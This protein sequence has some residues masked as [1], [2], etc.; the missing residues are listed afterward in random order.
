[1]QNLL[2]ATP[3]LAWLLF[4]A[5]ATVPSAPA[6]A[7]VTDPLAALADTIRASLLRT[8]PHYRNRG[9]STESGAETAFTG[10]YDWHSA[11]HGHWALL[12]M[13]RVRKDEETRTF[14][15]RRLHPSILAAEGTY[16][17]E[18]PDFEMPYGRAWLVLLLDELERHPEVSGNPAWL[19]AVRDLRGATERA[20]VDWLA[21]TRFPDARNFPRHYLAAQRFRG[22]HYSWLFPYVFLQLAG[23]KDRRAARAFRALAPRIDPWRAELATATHA[24]FDFLEAAA[25]L[26]LSDRLAGRT[27]SYACDRVELPAAVTRANAHR[28]GA[29]IADAWPCT[30]GDEPARAAFRKRF[31]QLLARPGLWRDDFDNV[32]HWVPQ[33]MWLGLWLASGRP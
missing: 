13:A 17:E 18:N 2:R 10:S 33:F 22:D 19:R 1:M 20:V 9:G 31:D 16:L 14:V 12:S 25:L 5:C 29:Y 30:L 11:V 26:A 21:R 24:E 28:P 27:T 8:A 4:S 32:G 6:P 7:P 23:V 15:L 3:V